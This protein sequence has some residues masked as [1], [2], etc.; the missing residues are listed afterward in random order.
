ML[1]ELLDGML[2]LSPTPGFSHQDAVLSLAVTLRQG[3]PRGMRVLVG[4]VAVRVGPDAELRPDVLVARYVDLTTDGLT[5]PPLLA[6]EVRLP[7]TG[8]VDRS[9]KKMLYARHGVRSYWIV[10]PET[11]SLTAFELD[12]AGC[13]CRWHT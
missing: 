12:A 4:P 9:L 7:G 6:V 13:T 11:P 1:A 10:D 8:L 5:G 3:C 2:L